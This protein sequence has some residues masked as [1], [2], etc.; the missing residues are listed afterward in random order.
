MA[1]RERVVN[2]YRQTGAQTIGECAKR[3]GVYPEK[4]RPHVKPPTFEAVGSKRMGSKM[5]WA[6][7]W[8]L[9]REGLYV[10]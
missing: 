9:T 7:V 10:D 2:Q 1:T 5:V 6:T 3:L 8:R 4:V